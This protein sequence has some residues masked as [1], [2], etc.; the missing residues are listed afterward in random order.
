MLQLDS[1]DYPKI[2]KLLK[3]GAVLAVPTE[4]VWG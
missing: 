4:T 1:T 2:A 3:S